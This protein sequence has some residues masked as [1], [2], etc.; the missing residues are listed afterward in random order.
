MRTRSCDDQSRPVRFDSAQILF[1]DRYWRLQLNEQGAVCRL[2]TAGRETHATA[3]WQ[4]K[5]GIC[6]GSIGK[7][8]VENRFF[9]SAHLESHAAGRRLDWRVQGAGA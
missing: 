2:T 1:L 3:E 9:H 4:F 6:W 5:Y 8:V 7:N